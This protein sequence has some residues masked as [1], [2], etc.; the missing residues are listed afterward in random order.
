[1]RFASREKAIF[2]QLEVGTSTIPGGGTMENLP[3]LLGRARALEVIIG[4]EDI[5][6]D[7]AERYGLINRAIPDAELDE[8]VF[9]F[10]WR[11]SQFDK[12]IIG[13]AKATI[14]QRC[15]GGP[16]ADDMVSSRNT[17]MQT[18]QLEQA[19]QSLERIA[20]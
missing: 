20:S 16:K 13:K 6:A 3:L 8:F 11:L 18:A 10:A 19:M 12:Y 1:M 2:G 14:T 15:G 4:S 9:R 17:F 7:I 5:N